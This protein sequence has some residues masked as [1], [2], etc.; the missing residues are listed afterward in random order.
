MN[1][2]NM[3]KLKLL[4]FLL[5]FVFIINFTSGCGIS[6]AKSNNKDSTTANC[7]EGLVSVE[8]AANS[9]VQLS[10]NEAKCEDFYSNIKL[11]L[12]NVGDKPITGYEISSVQDYENKKEV[13]SAQS[14]RGDGV[15]LKPNEAIEI[16]EAGGFTN[17]TSYGKPVGKLQRVVI[18][19]SFTDFEDGTRWTRENP[20]K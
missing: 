4:S 6:S 2:V 10:I 17:G 3:Q 12:K 8:Q 16:V 19:V 11:M 20:T 13:K 15:I 14:V 9:P 7:Q 5:S 18:R 1:G